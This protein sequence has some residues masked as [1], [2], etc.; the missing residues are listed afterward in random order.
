MLVLQTFLF[1]DCLKVKRASVHFV[2]IESKYCMLSWLWTVCA[3]TM[4]PCW[5]VYTQLKEKKYGLGE[6][7]TEMQ[8]TGSEKR[9]QMAASLGRAIMSTFKCVIS[10]CNLHWK[11]AVWDQNKGFIFHRMS[12]FCRFAIN[13]CD[14]I[15]V[16]LHWPY[17]GSFALL[18][19]LEVSSAWWCSVTVL[20]PQRCALCGRWGLVSDLV[21]H[22]VL[23][24]ARNIT[25]NASTNTLQKE[26]RS[27][28][29]GCI[30]RYCPM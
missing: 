5:D 18:L 13:R 28:V 24:I 21:A 14:C 10:G 3:L 17:L 26:L 23:V 9:C 19:W 29:S 7:S 15:R 11:T 16:H 22:P 2:L 30:L 8:D 4:A 25:A 1:V 6:K 20:V 12:S 27:V